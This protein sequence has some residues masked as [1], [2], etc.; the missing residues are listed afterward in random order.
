MQMLE[1]MQQEGTISPKDMYLLKVT[2]D[3]DEALHH[4]QHYVKENYTV[5]RLRPAG[6]W[7]KSQTRQAS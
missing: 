4:I 2:D 5:R 6:G 7:E 3:P 1:R